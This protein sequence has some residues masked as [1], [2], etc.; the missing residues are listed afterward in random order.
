[1]LV[2][3]RRSS[4]T[5]RYELSYFDEIAKILAR[6]GGRHIHIGRLEDLHLARHSGAGSPSSPG[7]DPARFVHR[8]WVRSVMEDTLAEEESTST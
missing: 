8:P 2:R 4:S 6:S 5:P 1:M 3:I 7:I